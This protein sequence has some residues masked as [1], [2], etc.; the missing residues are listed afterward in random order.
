MRD[1]VGLFYQGA[2][3]RDVPRRTDLGKVIP[4]NA[5]SNKRYLYGEQGGYCNG[6][7]HHFELRHLEV[8]HIIARSNGG[9]D[10]I[11]NLQL[12]CGACNAMKGTK[13]QAELLVMLTDKGWIKRRKTA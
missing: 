10:H 12:L 2:H 8:D 5:A 7:E 1:E 13:T 6:C 9:T 3:R 11:S 4:Y